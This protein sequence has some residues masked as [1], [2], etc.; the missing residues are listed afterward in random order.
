MEIDHSGPEGNA[1]AIMGVVKNLLKDSGRSD[2]IKDTMDL[3][4][5]GDYDN[6][7]AVAEEVSFG[8]ITFVD[9]DG[10]Y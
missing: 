7:C 5:S 8:T 2:E 10:D 4:M 1:F 9:D 6:L 3:M